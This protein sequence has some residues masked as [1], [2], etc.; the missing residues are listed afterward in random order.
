[1]K[2][3]ST[4][5]RLLSYPLSQPKPMLK[6]LGLLFIAALASAG[7]PWLIQYFIDEHIAKGDYS[8]G[9]LITLAAGY[10]ALQ[11]ISA[12]FQY[13]QSLQFSM[14][15]TNTI[16]TIRKQVFAGVIKQPLSAFDYTPAGKLV[17]RITNDTES[18]QQFYELLIATVVKNAVMILVMLGV[19]FFMSWQLTLVVLVLLPI[20]IGFMYLF[21][22]LSTESYR[23]MRDLLTDINANLSESI[24]GMSVV[25]LMQQEERFN[26]QFN[27]L[28]EEHLVASKRVIRLNGYLLRPLMDLLAG[29]ALMSLVAIFGFNGVEVIGVGVLYAFISYLGRV[30]EPLI[31]MTQQ[32]ALLQQALVS[33]ERVFELID[34]KEQ[35]YGDDKA[36]L[37]TGSIEIK[38]LTFS[39]D[40]KQEV[41]KDISIKADHQDFIALVGH[42]GSGKSTLASLLMGFYPTEVGEL[43]IDGRPLNTLAK[44][45][46]RKD[47]AMV[48]QDPHILPDSVRENVSLGRPVEDTEIWDALDK[49]GLSEQIRRYP[50]GLD[51]QLGQGET[52]LSAGQKQLLALARVLV[53]KPKIL[54]LDEATANIDSGTEALIQKSL[55]VLRQNMTLIVIAHRL[56]TILD[57]DQIVVLHHGDLVEKGTHKSLLAQNG[58]YAQMYQLQQASRHLQEIEEEE[59]NQLEEAV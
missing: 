15:A 39:Y 52:N 38:N 22:Q 4:F 55:A 34:A 42:T 8:Q 19:M 40:G 37:K 6:G 10:I 51:T 9:V 20:V 2:Q 24:Q 59:A 30:T 13:L 12:T 43:L 5:R 48:Q 16:K 50:N 14:V 1:M 56:S 32:L 31:E 18:L 35:T 25:Q 27:E 47:V 7:G 57:A 26:K 45:V 3:T 21:K 33:S 49:V 41:L 28:T 46:L 53:A 11:V 54:I 44:H 23:R 58:R 36:V 29:L 17:S